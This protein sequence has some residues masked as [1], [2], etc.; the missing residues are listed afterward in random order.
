M[1]G[2]SVPTSVSNGIIDGLRTRNNYEK[3]IFN[4]E[5]FDNYIEIFLHVRVLEYVDYVMQRVPHY[6]PYHDLFVTYLE[7]TMTQKWLNL[8]LW[9]RKIF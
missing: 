1:K 2:V 4:Q 3:I 7:S 5:V 8:V 6:K 9:K